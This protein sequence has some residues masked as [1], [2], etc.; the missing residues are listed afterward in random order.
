MRRFVCIGLALLSGCAVGPP[1]VQPPVAT[2]AAYKEPAPPSFE[3]AQG[4]KEAQP[5]DHLERS[6]WWEVFDDERLNELEEQVATGNQTL[7][8]AEARLRQA[9]SAILVSRSSRY[10]TFVPSPGVGGLRYSGH[11]PGFP[12]SRPS[13]SPN[14]TFPIDFTYEVDFWGRVRKTIEARRDEV[15]AST[16]EMQTARLGL[17]AEL[18]LSYFELRAAEAQSALLTE[19]LAAFQEMLVTTTHRFE[20]GVAPKADVSQAK[21]QLE[22][23]RAELTDLEVARAQHEHAVAVLTGR[24]PADL[25][26][27][28]GDGK[29]PEPPAI[30]VGVP[31]ELLE[32]R[33]D[34]AATERRTSAANQRIGIARTAFYPTVS[35]S[36]GIGMTGTSLLNWFTWPS[37]LWSLGTTAAVPLFDGGRRD[38][39]EEGAVAEYDVTVAEYRQTVLT[40]F[41][42]VED[43][44]ATLRVLETEER[45]QAEAVAA[46]RESLQLATNRY[47]GGVDTYLQVL[48]AQTVELVSERR[49]IDIRRRRILASVALIKALGG[50]WDAS[51]M[52]RP[53]Y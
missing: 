29:L 41:Q 31:S 25:A 5:G 12:T 4:W 23:A 38:A 50:G 6:G 22:S 26:V 43:N 32:R 30:P 20:G 24:P 9:R 51:E 2:P 11:R 1:Y 40:A 15:Q 10:P 53:V 3:T 7:Q 28:A 33:P 14:L 47:Q 17:Q 21:A 39:V 18:A 35:L 34:I 52:P 16:A 8:A 42:E 49:M 19:T 45:Q 44:L 48:S 36:G 27:A 46:A 13:D 37:R